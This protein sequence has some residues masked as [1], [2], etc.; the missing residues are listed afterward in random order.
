[1]HEKNMALIIDAS[2]PDMAEKYWEK[3]WHE[4]NVTLDSLEQGNNPDA[5]RHF[6]E[7]AESGRVI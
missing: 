1:M 5:I 7:Y 3:D 4:L 2:G 6:I